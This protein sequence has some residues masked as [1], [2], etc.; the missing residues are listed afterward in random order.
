MARG[1]RNFV[2]LGRS[3][4][5]RPQA[6]KL[7]ELL[8]DNGASVT[9]VRG[10]VCKG[11]DVMRAVTA[12]EAT[13]KA[14]G[15]VI[16]GA[17][18][19]HEAI[20]SRMTSEMWHTGIQPKWAGSWNLHHAL[21][22]HDAALDFFLL[23]SS[24]SGSIG[25]A[26]ET[27]YCASNGFLDAFAHWRRCQGKPATSVGLGMIAEVGYLHENPE[28]EAILLRRGIQA[29]NEP[30]FLNI[31]DL[32]LSGPQNN[33]SESRE[34]EPLTGPAAAHILTGLELFSV[35]KLMDQGFEVNHTTMD[36]PRASLLSAALE[37]GQEARARKRREAI[38]DDVHRAASD[39]GWMKSLPGSVTPLFKAEVDASSLGAAA[40]R[41]IKKQF[42]N[43]IL[44]PQDKID[45]KKPLAGFGVDSMIA[46]EFRTWF[47]GSLKVDI[48]FLDLL[49]QNKSLS[50]LAAA[51]EAS[52]SKA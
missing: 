7:V 37:A 19:L 9:V 31:L 46:S 29:L 38:G 1:A 21:E 5:D 22:G 2:F 47:W 10:D 14:I 6:K 3:G 49:S 24:V 41:L 51:V 12:C 17:M 44:M 13:G 32:A 26:T 50:D 23:M 52:L 45:D 16:Q 33:E 40:L 11:D 25:I 34:A 30:E 4:T 43:L 35:F 27:N 28:I 20:F 39:V 48:P 8:Q 15:G 36:D 42:S 18:G